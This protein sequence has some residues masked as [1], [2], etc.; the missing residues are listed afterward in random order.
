MA[1]AIGDGDDGAYCD[2]WIAAGD[3]LGGEADAAL[4]K[5][6]VASARALYLRASAF[7]AASFHPLYGAPVDPHLLAAFRKEVAAL[8]KGLALGP[9]PAT[10]L[11]IPFGETSLP[12]LFSSRR[13]VSRRRCGR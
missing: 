6:H 9:H 8:D 7:Y 10:P 2:A 3:R 12:G 11:A 1:A 5:G 13:T 4:A